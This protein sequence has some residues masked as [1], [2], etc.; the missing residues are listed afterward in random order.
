MNS[1]TLIDLCQHFDG[2]LTG[3]TSYLELRAAGN[4]PSCQKYIVDL[5]K[6]LQS[7]ENIL[8]MMKMEVS[9]QKAQLTAVEGIKREFSSFLGGLEYTLS[10]IPQRL[11]NTQEHG[12]SPVETCS[13]ANSKP[14]VPA[15]QCNSSARH[16][17]T[18]DKKPATGKPLCPVIEYLRID[19]FEDVPKYIK[20][21]YTYNQVNTMV[22]GLNSSLKAKYKILRMKRSTLSDVNRKHFEEFKQQENKDTKGVYFVVEKDL[23]EFADMK[24]DAANRAMLTIL[25]HTKRIREIRETGIIRFAVLDPC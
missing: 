7:L 19:E 2:K 23:K 12:N 25:R 11:P 22:D 5:S 6:E 8:R 3:V 4:D 17:D 9:K 10:N 1:A 21:R 15:N 13:S 14:S 24:L 18:T 16:N 20:S